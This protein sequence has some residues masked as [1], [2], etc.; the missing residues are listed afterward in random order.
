M[1]PIAYNVRSLFVR[2]TT[3]IATLLGVALVVFVLASSQMLAHGIKR[4]MGRS[5]NVDNAIVLRKGS[6][7]ELS[8]SV[9]TRLVNLV[10]AAPGVK[11]GNDGAPLGA[12]ELVLV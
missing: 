7:A 3:T 12:G 11:R 9:E 6:D 1:V 2:K 10:K 4:T 5:G 8:S